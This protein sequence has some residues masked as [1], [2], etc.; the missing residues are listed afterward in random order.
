MAQKPVEPTTPAQ[1]GDVLPAFLRGTFLQKLSP[2]KRLVI[3]LSALAA[4]LF[5]PWLGA[6]GFWD[7]W[8]PHYGEVAREMIARGDYIHPWWESAWFFSKPALDLWLMAAGMLAAGSNDAG[9][10]LGEYTEWCVRFPYAAISAIGA[11]LMFV[12]ANRLLTRRSAVLTTV[13][14]L[15]SP[16]FVFLA[17]QA[18]PDPVFVGLL[19]GAMACL[20]ITLF[21]SDEHSRDGWCAAF[22]CFV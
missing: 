16:L 10:Y 21:D 1:W 4:F 12:M 3:A 6:T 14:M 20:M 13:A 8:E 22:Y 17:R 9:R 7:P 15:T 5:L 11:V 18:V 2:E 19:E